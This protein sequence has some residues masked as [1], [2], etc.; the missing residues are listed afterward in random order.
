M[1]GISSSYIP[2]VA[3][4][5]NTVTGGFYKKHQSRRSD[6]S[7]FCNAVQQS[8]VSYSLAKYG[9]CLQLS[10]APCS[11]GISGRV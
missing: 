10:T 1:S 9:L 3:L 4:G 6:N 5:L 2:V 8:E 7:A 11:P